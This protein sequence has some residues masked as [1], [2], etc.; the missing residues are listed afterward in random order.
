M[1]IFI[2]ISQKRV[3]GGA[4]ETRKAGKIDFIA[5]RWKRVNGYPICMWSEKVKYERFSL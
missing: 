1:E 3:F 4:K 2:K 5:K